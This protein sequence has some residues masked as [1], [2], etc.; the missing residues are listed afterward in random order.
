MYPEIAVCRFFSSTSNCQC[1]LFSKKNPIIRIFC[2]SGSLVVPM[3]PDEWSST[4]LLKSPFV[5]RVMYLLSNSTTCFFSLI[6]SMV[7]GTEALY[8]SYGP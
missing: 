2:L 5:D 7:K 1:S 3:N 4:V 8:R 6:C